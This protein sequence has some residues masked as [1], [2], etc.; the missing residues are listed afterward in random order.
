M[1]YKNNSHLE[2][3]LK[4]F[5]PLDNPGYAVLI[6][7]QWGIGKTFVT[8]KILQGMKKDYLYVSLYG[9]SSD[10]EIEDA[11]IAQVLQNSFGGLSKITM[12]AISYSSQIVRGNLKKLGLEKLNLSEF[13]E[14]LKNKILVFDDLERSNLDVSE[15]LGHL[16]TFVEHA[17]LKVILICNSEQFPDPE[18]FRETKEKI[19]GHTLIVRPEFGDAFSA[20]CQQI[21]CPKTKKF[22][23]EN[24][25]LAGNIFKQSESKNL[26]VLR[27]TL[28]EFE[29]LYR[30][31]PNEVENYP[32]NLK[33]LFSIFAAYSFETK[34]GRLQKADFNNRAYSIVWAGIRQKGKSDEAKSAIKVSSERYA[35]IDLTDSVLTDD[36]LAEMLFD[37]RYDKAKIRAS[38]EDSHRF[39]SIEREPEWRTVWHWA[40]RADEAIIS[41]F[42]TL[43][44][45][46]N[47]REY[48]EIGVILHVFGIMLGSVEKKLSSF[49]IPQV[50]EMCRSYVDDILEKQ[51][52]ETID[53]RSSF[54]FGDSHG[55][56][57]TNEDS[58]EFRELREYL[59][60]AN[61]T[62]L[63]QNYD[64]IGMELIENLPDQWS[65]FC[66]KVWGDGAKGNFQYKPI[67]ANADEG[68]FVATLLSLETHIQRKVFQALNYRYREGNL[69]T[70]LPSERQWVKRV[71]DLLLDKKNE[72]SGLPGYRL[73]R[74]VEWTFTGIKLEAS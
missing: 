6:E 4:Y 68:K 22:L 64:H 26:R 54:T 41:A 69:E 11:I 14:K 35:G 67:F 34:L 10:A 32:E 47:A 28:H 66:E 51:S 29:R 58:D 46:F 73:D 71:R 63:S 60:T 70:N 56:G 1:N 49:T 3:Y 27:Q 24:E 42:E 18:K 9:V 59:R 65:E 45:N 50:K 72:M 52:L 21:H 2:D 16:N 62:A 36:L 40:E 53:D 20:F 48:T 30:C 5:F 19:V 12:K 17:G 23:N 57:F 25:A 61:K 7:G 37:G 38:I 55:L 39:R 31:L 15:L 13:S 33:L 8:K 44:K 43:L 74:F